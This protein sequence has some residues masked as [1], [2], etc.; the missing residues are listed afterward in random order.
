MSDDESQK[1]PTKGRRRKGSGK[2]PAASTAVPS[3]AAPPPSQSSE[4]SSVA[5]SPVAMADREGLSPLKIRLSS[6]ETQD[7]TADGSNETGGGEPEL[8]SEPQVNGNNSIGEVE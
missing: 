2:G 4:A 3:A 5:L 1:Y 6:S 8:T 7:D